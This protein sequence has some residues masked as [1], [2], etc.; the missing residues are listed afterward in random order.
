MVNLDVERTLC[1]QKVLGIRICR[2]YQKQRGHCLLGP[3]A[4]QAHRVFLTSAL[5]RPQ[6]LIALTMVSLY[7]YAVFVYA[8]LPCLECLLTSLLTK[9]FLIQETFIEH[10]LCASFGA[11]PWGDKDE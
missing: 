6:V 3:V 1:N 8:G 7:R 5:S 11:R 2:G 10:L 4:S 9:S